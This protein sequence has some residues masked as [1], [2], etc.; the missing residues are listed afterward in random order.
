MFYGFGFLAVWVPLS[1]ENIEANL[2]R[3]YHI[4]IRSSIDSFVKTKCYFV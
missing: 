4:E 3:F 2:I 1:T